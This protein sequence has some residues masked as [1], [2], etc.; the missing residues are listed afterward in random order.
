MRHLAGRIDAGAVDTVLNHDGA[1][2]LMTRTPAAGV[3]HAARSGGAVP[4]MRRGDVAVAAPDGHGLV[5]MAP[6]GCVAVQTPQGFPA[7]PLLEAYEHAARE[8]FAGTDTASCV[9]RFAPELVTRWIAGDPGNIKI[10]YPRD[11]V[12]A[13]QALARLGHR[14][15]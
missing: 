9:E 8:G 1:R 10:T 14:P 11:L 2:P 15:G 7:A 12:V 4:G 3:L 6:E 5:A 13:E